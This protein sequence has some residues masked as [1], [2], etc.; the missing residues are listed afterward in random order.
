MD[1]CELAKDLVSQRVRENFMD[2]RKSFKTNPDP[3]RE[4]GTFGKF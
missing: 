1:D 3:K 4:R 2:L